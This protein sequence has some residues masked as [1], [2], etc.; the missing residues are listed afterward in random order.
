LRGDESGDAE[1]PL[2]EFFLLGKTVLKRVPFLFQ[3]TF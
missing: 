3:I 2:F 1:I